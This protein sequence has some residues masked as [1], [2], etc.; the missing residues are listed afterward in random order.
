VGKT[1]TENNMSY[2]NMGSEEENKCDLETEKLKTR[3][4]M[5]REPLYQALLFQ[6]FQV[7]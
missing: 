3:R 2:V 4:V 5:K 1:E 6:L 7:Q